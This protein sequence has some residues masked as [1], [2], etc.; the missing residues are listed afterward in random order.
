MNGKKLNRREILQGMLLSTGATFLP[1]MHLALAADH[2]AHE[3][4]LEEAQRSWLSMRRPVQHVGIPGYEFQAGVLWNGA[5][6]FGPL[7]A[8]RSNPGMMKEL[9]LLG[10]NLL[11]VSVGYGSPAKFVDRVGNRDAAITRGLEDG[12]LPIPHI[13]T[14][15]GVLI[16][17]QRFFAHLMQRSFTEGM[18]PRED[19]LLIVQVRFSV[20][21]TSKEKTLGHLWLHMGDTSQVEFGYKAGQGNELGQSIEHSFASPYGLAGNE[22]RYVVP[23]PERGT[24]HWHQEID[25]PQGMQSRPQRVLEW[26]VPLG[27]GEET[28]LMLTVPYKP[29]NQVVAQ[30]LT[31]LNK[32]ELFRAACAFWKS[33]VEGPTS[34][35]TPNAF[36]NDYTKAVAGQM[37]QQIGYRHKA[38]VWMYKT[39][40]NHYEMYWP[41]NAA[42]ALPTLDLRGLTHYSRPVLKSF[43][44]T[45]TEDFGKLTRQDMGEGALIPGEGFSRRPGF[46]GNFGDWTANTLLLSHGTEL[47]ALAAHYR[48]T[49]DRAWLGEGPGSPLQAILDACDWMAVQRRRTMREENGKKVAHWGLLPA[50]SAHDWLS[51]NTIFNDA[52][53]IFG[54]IEA[55]RLL[56]EIQHSRAD[57]LAQELN[58]Y[59]SCL[60]ER[61]REARD[62]SRPLPLPGGATLP[63]VPR[64]VYELDWAKTDWTYTGYGPLRAGAWGA[65]DPQDELVDQ[66]LAFLEAGM[67]KGEGT[68]LKL[69]HNSYGQP[70]ADENFA[71]VNAPTADRHFLWKHYV[72]YETM[73]PIGYDLFLQRDDLPRFFEWFSHNFSMVLHKEFRVGVES[74]D[75]VPSCAPGEGERWR[76]I[77]NMFVNE[78]GGYDGSQQSL[79]LL[80]A[81]PQVWLKPGGRFGVKEMGTHFGGH[82]DLEV[83]VDPSGNQ[84][85]VAARL[86]LAILPTEI[87]L[88][89][90]PGNSRQKLSSVQINGRQTAILDRNTVRLPAEIKGEYKIDAQFS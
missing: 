6:V 65:L 36:L 38:R 50:A 85:R 82:V 3:W 73:W 30:K 40:P 62:K 11:H 57:E 68:Y 4:T 24:V 64:D 67:P 19:D 21:N 25:P 41:C 45:Q 70:T 48:I 28:D 78:R 66:S 47:W 37:A 54:H 56:R 71:D 42:K 15:D 18:Q 49:R 33:V 69:A 13:Q 23:P 35:E 43:I 80:Q 83:E 86:N 89:L 32:D 26:S 59:R 16:W 63:Y 34:I 14:K 2:S 7:K 79:W 29:V 87:R 88:R 8:A 22:V 60:R 81:I 84:L 58:A 10:N 5:L 1:P 76:A 9:E 90:R 12:Y 20:Q 52:F 55:V 74:I 39:S 51:G 75:G 53:C 44:D 61:Y 77:R 27:P 46:L 31:D 72:E 17:R